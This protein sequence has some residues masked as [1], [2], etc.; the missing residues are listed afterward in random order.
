MPSFPLN[1]NYTGDIIVD[2]GEQI[3][4]PDSSNAAPSIASSSKPDT[5][6]RIT[7][8]GNIRFAVD[9]LHMC[10][11]NN[12]ELDV[13]V[14]V[15][16]PDG[17]ENIPSLSFSYDDNTG[18]FR[19]GTDTIGISTGG[20]EKLRIDGNGVVTISGSAAQVVYPSY[21]KASLPVGVSGG[22]IF[23]TDDVGGPTMAFFDGSDWRRVADRAI[24]S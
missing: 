10:K 20:S 1:V 16:V 6:M 11:L 19:P 2:V 24:I 12:A 18:V 14:P 5:G 4:V 17:T 3:L 21:A 7:A 13:D 22:M 9:G 15:R 8:D 23:V